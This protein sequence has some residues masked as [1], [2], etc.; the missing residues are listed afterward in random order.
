MDNC[1]F[2]KCVKASSEERKFLSTMVLEKYVYAK[3]EL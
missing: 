1:F 3:H 2:D